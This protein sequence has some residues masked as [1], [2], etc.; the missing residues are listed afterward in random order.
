MEPLKHHSLGDNWL[1]ITS[2]ATRNTMNAAIGGAGMLL[3]PHSELALE[4]IQ[5]ISE[6]T[7]IATLNGYPKCTIISTYSRTNVTNE[8][9]IQGYYSEL[10]TLI[11]LVP[12]HSVLLLCSDMNAEISGKHNY[13]Q[14]NNRNDELLCELQHFTNLINLCTKFQKR[15]GKKWSFMC[16]NGAKE[17]LDHILMN[18]K[19]K[20]IAIDCPAYNTLRSVSSDHEIVIVKCR[21]CLRANKSRKYPPKF[22][23]SKSRVTKI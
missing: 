17:Q 12:K 16:A 7:M 14:T 4:N 15:T 13:H 1:L 20:D 10:T 18:K 22:D 11:H 3:D 21:L 5:T 2:S 8:D 9:T 19:W 6:R 23:W